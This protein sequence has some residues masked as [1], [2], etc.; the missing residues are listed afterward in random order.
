[1]R[2]EGTGAVVGDEAVAVDEPEFGLGFVLRETF[3]DEEVRE[4]FG[5]ADACATGSEE[6]GWMPPRSVFVSSLSLR[7]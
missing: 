3:V 2:G 6:Y 1:M 7:S 4:L 5:D